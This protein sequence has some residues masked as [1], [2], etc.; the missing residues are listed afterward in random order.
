MKVRRAQPS[1]AHAVAT[2]Q[3]A[4]WRAAYRGILPDALLDGLVLAEREARRREHFTTPTPGVTNWVVGH[5]EVVGW[6][7]VGPPREP[8]VPPGT[9]ELYALYVHPDAQGWGHGRA[10]LEHALRHARDA[11]AP[12]V[13]LWVLS[14]NRQARA[15]YSAAGFAV[16]E[17]TPEREFD[18]TGAMTV[19]MRC[20]LRDAQPFPGNTGQG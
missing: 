12:C 11:G 5:E 10:L 6:G 2:L 15:F 20:E 8:D 16:D 7:A 9:L 1:D 17:T 18:D 19:R 3:D 14:A 13:T 4:A